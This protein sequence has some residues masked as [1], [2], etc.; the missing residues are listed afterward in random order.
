[1]YF[2]AENVPVDLFNG[3]LGYGSLS[4]RSL[5]ATK[6]L[7]GILFLP[8]NKSTEAISAAEL[9]NTP[10]PQL[11]NNPPLRRKQPPGV[12]RTTTPLSGGSVWVVEAN[13]R[14]AQQSGLATQQDGV[15]TFCQ[16]TRVVLMMR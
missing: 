6:L 5:S 8:L 2:V 7:Y 4:S 1:M 9:N 14:A 13:K 12:H 15:K 10:R 3:R 16:C 11:N